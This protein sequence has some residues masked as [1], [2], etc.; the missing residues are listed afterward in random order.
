VDQIFVAILAE[1]C[2]KEGVAMAMERLA[3]FSDEKTEGRNIH[4]FKEI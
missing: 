3:N 1:L 4:L 2:S